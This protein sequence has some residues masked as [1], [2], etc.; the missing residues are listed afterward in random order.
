MPL[1]FEAPPEQ[2]FEVIQ[3]GLTRLGLAESE[4]FS[5]LWGLSGTLDATRGLPLCRAEITPD[6][7]EPSISGWRYL[8]LNEGRPFAFADLGPDVDG[9]LV[10]RSLMQGPSLN[11]FVAA[12]KTVRD[13]A[14]DRDGVVY[15]RL[16]EFPHIGL[17]MF[18]LK[19]QADQFVTIRPVF[20]R[21]RFKRVMTLAEVKRRIRQLSRLRASIDDEPK[22]VS[23]VGVGA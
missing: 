9:V 15:L 5:Q 23:V 2:G 19:G 17:R 8:L 10:L 4:S 16:L 22:L 21:R 18:W 7:W 3:A 11:G 13:V 12:L 20:G 6:W 1:S 14:A